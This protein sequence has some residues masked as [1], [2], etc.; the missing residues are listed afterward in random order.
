MTITIF[1]IKDEKY[2]KMVRFKSNH[3]QFKEVYGD[4]ITTFHKNTWL[5]MSELATWA[6]NELNE[7]CLFETE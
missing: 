6:N 4:W 5:V 7:E 1:E 3:P 2:D